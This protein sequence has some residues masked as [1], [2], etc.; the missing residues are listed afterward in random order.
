ML[1]SSLVIHLILLVLLIT[2]SNA[3]RM[4]RTHFGVFTVQ[5]DG[6]TI[7]MSGEV[8]RESL[9][10]FERMQKRFPGLKR[11]I[12]QSCPGSLDDW[13]NLEIGRRIYESGINTAVEDGGLI[14]SGGVDLFLAGV[15]RTLGRDVQVGVHGWARGDLQASDF[16]EGAE[17]H[18]PYLTYYQDI[19]MSPEE[20]SAFY[21]F[22]LEAAPAAEIHY[23]SKE[24]ITAFGLER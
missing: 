16:P 17:E 18:Q 14:A 11:L 15:R 9:A 12:I 13:T 1:R 21:Y 5:P 23:M 6:K 3:C 7:F 8:K 20:A 2:S 4:E 10:H 19:G 22:T 24:E